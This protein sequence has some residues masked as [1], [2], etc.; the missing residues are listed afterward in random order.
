MAVDRHQTLDAPMQP[1]R[2]PPMNRPPTPP[3]TPGSEA[4]VR[5]GDSDFQ[6]LSPGTYVRC[7][8]SHRPVPLDALR[9]WSVDAQE[10]YAGPDEA[11][12]A[13]E[14]AGLVP[15]R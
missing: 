1:I 5:Y 8:I 15:R 11:R 12:Q 10:A 2:E 6:V 3:F 13:L 4:K 7:A 14:Q 9:Y